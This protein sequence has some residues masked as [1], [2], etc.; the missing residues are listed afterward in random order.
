[1][2]K[3]TRLL[4]VRLKLIKWALA[5]SFT[6]IIGRL[7]YLQITLTNIFSLLGKRNFTRLEKTVSPRGNILDCNG[8]LLATNRPVTNLLWQGTGK[9]VFDE[10]FNTIIVILETIL[11]KKLSSPDIIAAEKKS[12][13]LLLHED[14][15]YEQLGLIVELLPA[16]KNLLITTHFKRYYPHHH[17]ACHV[18]GHLSSQTCNEGKMGLEK[19]LEALLRGSPGEVVTTINSVG[20]QLSEEEIKK[21]RMGETVQ[22]T[23]DLSLQEIVESVF[24]M[25][26]AGVFIIM[27]PKTGALEAVVS[28]PMFDPNTFLSPIHVEEWAELQKK[29]P[30]LNRAFNAYPPA[31]LF[32]LVTITAALENNIIDP[33]AE[34]YCTGHTT[35]GGRTYY[36]HNHYGHGKLSLKEA[37]AKSCNIPFYEIGKKIHIDTLANYAHKFGL[38][39]K[40][41]II[42]PEKT[43]LIPTSQ[44]KRLVK[45]EPWFQGETLSAVI[46]QSYFLITPMQALRMVAGIC[47]GYMVKPRILLHEPIEQEPLQISWSSR[48]FLKDSMK[49]VIERGGGQ[50]L[51]TVSKNSLEIFGKTGTAQVSSLEKRNLGPEFLEH[52]WFV[53]HVT[54]KDY[55]PLVLVILIENA[56]SSRV[57]MSTA[58]NFLVNYCHYKDHGTSLVTNN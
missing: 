29:Q 14:M 18:L 52:A 28:R 33:N 4:I 11:G 30:F 15:S 49:M 55:D 7:F 8:N 38:G 47:E 26:I 21:A 24:P 40:T 20:A 58:K 34:I 37:I 3:A 42:F 32:K 1:M 36:C 19:V 6:I 17:I 22:T 56:G 46:G 54:Y 53:A 50:R 16:H 57:A 23:L 5:L 44:W 43:G 51:K 27:D 48:E 25:T 12:K 13:R 2:E 9:R 39:L 45:Q 31:S 10:D 41:N 35:F